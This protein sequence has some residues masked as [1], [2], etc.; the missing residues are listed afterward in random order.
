MSLSHIDDERWLGWQFGNLV[1]RIGAVALLA[2][3]A[4]VCRAFGQDSASVGATGADPAEFGYVVLGVVVVIAYRVLQVIATRLKTP[5]GTKWTNAIAKTIE[6][7]FGTEASWRNRFV[8]KAATDSARE[9][10]A[11]EFEQKL[12]KM[13]YPLAFDLKVLKVLKPGKK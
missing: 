3:V 11:G 4:L 10:V 2:L 8:V 9:K 1:A 5:C 7:L 6:L 13:F 12:V